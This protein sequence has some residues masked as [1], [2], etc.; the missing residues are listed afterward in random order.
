MEKKGLIRVFEYERLCV[1]E[2]GFE[3]RHWEAVAR[4]AERQK[5]K[6]LEVW[7][8]SI[9]FLNWVG[10]IEAEGLVIEVLPKAETARDQKDSEAVATKWQGIL[11]ALLKAAGYIELRAVDAA[12]LK[13]RGSTL[14]DILFS[15]YLDSLEQLLREGLVKR[16]RPVLKTRNAI[17][18]RIDYA[19]NIRDNLVHAE[20]VAT[21]AY[22]YDRINRLN[23]ILKAATEASALFAPSGYARSRARRLGFE[24]AGWPDSV[25][26]TADFKAAHIDRKTEGYR[27]P[28]SLARLILE[29]RN[30]DLSSG[31]ERVFSLLF[32]MNDLWEKAIFARLKREAASMPDVSV[33]A[34]RS[35]ASG[36]RG[37]QDHP[38]GH[39][40]RARG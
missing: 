18:G 15:Q 16:Y 34:Q 31:R 11:I 10:V 22:E 23:M 28:L 29:K 33:S 40:P 1:G 13:F 3:K 27:R 30:S 6:Y 4:W 12:S 9:R 2:R 8:L 37:R 14:L 7:A 19:A 32:D 21:V 24:F 36:R 5:D 17:K 35:K 20:R 39:P 38:P 26:G 25:I